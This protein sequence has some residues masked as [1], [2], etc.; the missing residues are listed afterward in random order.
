[1]RM[2][3]RRW[4]HRRAQPEMAVCLWDR[5][6][7][8]WGIPLFLKNVLPR[9]GFFLRIHGQDGFELVAYAVP[10]GRPLVPPLTMEMAIPSTRP[11]PCPVCGITGAR[12]SLFRPQFQEGVLGDSYEVVICE[13]CGAGFADGIPSQGDLDT[14]Y[15]K[16]SKYAY[17]G[18]GGSES[19][20]DFRRF[21]V[22][23][24]QIAPLV[25]SPDVRILDI[26]CATGGLLS[27][28][29]R[30]GYRNLL[31]ADPSPECASSAARLHGVRVE[32]A[33]VDQIAE[34]KATFDLITMVGVLEHLRE[35]SSAA[36]AAVALLAGDGIFL[37]AVPDVEGL[38]DCRNAPFQQFS[39]EHVNFFSSQSLDRLMNASGLAPA[40]TWRTTVEW[41]EGITEPI[42]SA[43]YR[44]APAGTPKRDTL[45]GP[46]LG[47]YVDVCR[48]NEA[49]TVEM[50]GALVKSREPILVWG[51][52][53][54]TRRLLATTPLADAHITGFVDSNPHLQGKR[55]A[56]REVLPPAQ[57]VGRDE[58]ILIGSLAFEKEIAGA[59]RDRY[60]LK[61]RVLTF[62][63]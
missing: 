27:V 44:R 21:E 63:L 16:R 29:K 14:H 57:I 56:G 35:P 54:F 18:D 40:A 22:I 10:C 5:P 41:R 4:L 51:A 37:A 20:Y 46:E 43:A 3:G 39:M 52:G 31:G 42:V 47:R 34:W 25:A 9:L 36:Q 59:I 8:P 60:Q 19:P 7:D 23:A 55:L 13:R 33:T 17:E 2:C 24:D 1:M 38:A 49:A 50:I 28:F 62:K 30:R 61:N 32:V 48:K 12:E 26:G 15:S 45:T 58:A 11:R 53:A 6:V